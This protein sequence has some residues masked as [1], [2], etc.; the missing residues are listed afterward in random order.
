MKKLVLFAMSIAIMT[1]CG[2]SKPTTSSVP[3]QVPPQ[4][5][6]VVSL[7]GEQVI[8]ETTVD[9]GYAMAKSLS[10]D[11]MTL[12]DVAYRWFSGTHK[13]DN[14]QVAIEMARREATSA[15]SRTLNTIVE[16]TA[17][18]GTLEVNGKVYEALQSYWS[19]QSLSILNGCE[20]FGEVVVEYSPNTRMY[21][22]TAKVAMR[23]DR[24]KKALDSAGT[25]QPEG[26]TKEELNEFVDLNKA[27]IEAAKGN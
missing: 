14:K 2:A 4:R 6:N 26:L 9:N 15:V 19:Q 11:G 16:D 18:K 5:E 22:A 17:K 1:A 10:E 27:I 25:F 21:T 13:A 23:G 7:E 8:Q 20:P 24:F 3:T 12:I